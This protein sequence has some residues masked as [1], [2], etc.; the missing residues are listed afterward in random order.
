M[1]PNYRPNVAGILQRPDGKI[2]IAERSDIAGAWQ[3]PQGGVDKGE[4][5]EAALLREMEEEI[6]VRP[7]EYEVVERRDGYR[8]TFPGG[9][10]KR[11]KFHGQ[12][13]TYFLC[14]L[15]G[16]ESVIDLDTEEREF[17]DFKWIEPDEFDL[18]WV[19]DFKREVY[20]RVMRDFFGAT[21]V[22]SGSGAGE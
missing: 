15:I 7:T 18:G 5:F 19:P 16:D 20:V 8:Y 12:E 9:I 13:Q 21:I 17:S 1:E 11:G 22:E 6:S 3:F 4:D 10:V 2:L 14:R